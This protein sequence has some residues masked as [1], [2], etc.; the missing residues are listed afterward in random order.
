MSCRDG[1]EASR[2]DL[3]DMIVL[4]SRSV[5]E[6][7]PSTATLQSAVFPPEGATLAHL[8]VLLSNG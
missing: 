8:A 7:T 1:T 4:V 5:I 6:S 3:F 2:A